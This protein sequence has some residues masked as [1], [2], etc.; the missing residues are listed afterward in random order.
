MQKCV[1]AMRLSTSVD[2]GAIVLLNAIVLRGVVE[3]GVRVCVLYDAS[4]MIAVLLLRL[5]LQLRIR[6]G[7]RDKMEEYSSTSWPDGGHPPSMRQCS[8]PRCTM[9]HRVFVNP[10]TTGT[11]A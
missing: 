7:G 3:V 9:I 10:Q 6:G 2:D 4:T 1:C 5:S 8:A 11:L